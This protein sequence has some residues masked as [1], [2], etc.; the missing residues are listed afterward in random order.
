MPARR[1]RARRKA[2]HVPTFGALSDRT[3]FPAQSAE[4]LF[5]PLEAVDFPV[6]VVFSA[7][8]ISKEE[9]GRDVDT[10]WAGGVR[11]VNLATGDDAANALALQAD[12]KVVLAGTQDIQGNG[13]ATAAVTARLRSDGSLD[14]TY[15]ADG[16]T[17]FRPARDVQPN[18]L[19]S[20]RPA[21]S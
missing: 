17:S 8:H 13:A 4:P 9:G 3:V 11:H 7:R 19:S 18:D 12:G 10:I 21:R 15:D 16:G 2:T 6:D 1:V 5:A 14:T 20:P